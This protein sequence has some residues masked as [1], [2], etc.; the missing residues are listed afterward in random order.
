MTIMLEQARL[1]FMGSL[2]ADSFVEF[3]RHR[4]SRL[5]LAIGVGAVSDQAITVDIS[6]AAELVDAFEMA[7]SLGPHDCIIFDVA[8]DRLALVS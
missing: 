2:R 6:G 7:C 3:A 5:G 8:R 1:V 4:A